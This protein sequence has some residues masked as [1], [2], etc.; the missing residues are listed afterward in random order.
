M[1]V[2]VRSQRDISGANELRSTSGAA[3]FIRGWWAGVQRFRGDTVKSSK[4]QAGYADGLAWRDFHG[5]NRVPSETHATDALRRFRETANP[6]EAL[7]LYQESIGSA[8]QM[9]T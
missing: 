5:P 7:R 4:Y 8:E 6:A 9:E 1:I 2:R 3:D